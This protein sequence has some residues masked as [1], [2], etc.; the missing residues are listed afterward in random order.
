MIDK[1]NQL[2]IGI[3]VDYPNIV[4]SLQEYASAQYPDISMVKKYANRLGK[5]A[6]LKVYGDWNLLNKQRKHLKKVPGTKLINEPHLNTGTGKKKDTVDM[7]MAFDIGLCLEK[8]PQIDLYILVSGDA[9]FIPVLRQLRIRGKEIL[10]IA[11][12]NS[13]S[14]HL[15]R[16]FKNIITYQE[17]ESY[18]AR[19]STKQLVKYPS[20]KIPAKIEEV[21]I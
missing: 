2:S 18:F 6:L 10:I 5:I 13:L 20:S 14:W 4:L 7:R 15:K 1:K 3:F 11:E 9:D 21:V 17:L 12:Q 16:K 8:S 19:R